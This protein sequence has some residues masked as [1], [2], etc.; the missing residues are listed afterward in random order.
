MRSNLSLVDSV[1]LVPV[2]E[3]G[4]AA[5]GD[6]REAIVAVPADEDRVAGRVAVRSGAAAPPRKGCSSLNCSLST[7]IRHLHSCRR[8]GPRERRAAGRRCS[9]GSAHRP[10][11]GWTPALRA[12]WMGPGFTTP[13]R[14]D[15]QQRFAGSHSGAVPAG[16]RP[17]RVLPRASHS[18]IGPGDLSSCSSQGEDGPSTARRIAHAPG[19]LY[20]LAGHSANPPRNGWNL[21]TRPD[22]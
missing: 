8:R 10:R 3:E 14:R 13:D 18:A 1:R 6:P 9:I 11:S 20:W 22:V 2:H 12:D 16:R 7:S 21:L 15:R 17:A 19:T 4:Q 5:A